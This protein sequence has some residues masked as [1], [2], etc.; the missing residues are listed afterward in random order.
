VH[1]L[2]QRSIGNDGQHLKLTVRANNASSKTPPLE[3]IAFGFG[4]QAETL[5]AH[6]AIDLVY[7]LEANV[8]NGTESLQ[9]N[10]KDFRYC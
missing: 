2:Q 6:P 10:V 1:V 9:L 3:A 8:W 5:R 4:D 7:T